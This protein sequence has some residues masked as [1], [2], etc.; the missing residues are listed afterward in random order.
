MHFYKIGCR[1]EYRMFS[2][3]VNYL[4]S[5]QFKVWGI[6]HKKNFNKLL[7][8]VVNARKNQIVGCICEI[9]TQKNK[10]DWQDCQSLAQAKIL[11]IF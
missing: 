9:S 2:I 1:I 6:G 10:K 7:Q 3:K 5:A 8:K 11:L 4:K